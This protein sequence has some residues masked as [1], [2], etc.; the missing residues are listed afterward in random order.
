MPASTTIRMIFPNSDGWRLN[1][2]T[3][4]QRCEPR[5]A[6]PAAKTTASAP[7]R[8]AQSAHAQRAT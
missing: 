4:I 6:S 8:P 7:S 2:P 3:S 1:G 5:V